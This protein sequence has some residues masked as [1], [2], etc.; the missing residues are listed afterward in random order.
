MEKVIKEL[1]FQTFEKK[2][3]TIKQI[4]EYLDDNFLINMIN[5]YY[6]DEYFTNRR[7]NFIKNEETFKEIMKKIKSLKWKLENNDSPF[8]EE[9][10]YWF[11]I[12]IKDMNIAK[13][14]VS[15]GLCTIHTEGGIGKIL[16]INERYYN[17][18]EE[19]KNPTLK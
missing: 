18:I 19:N 1:N 10:E 7:R 14:M 4:N 2:E 5:E 6:N 11:L 17:A 12:P 9:Q 15:T 3:L 13:E 8:L 16:V